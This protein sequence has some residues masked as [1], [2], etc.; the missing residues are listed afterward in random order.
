MKEDEKTVRLEVQDEGDGISPE[1]MP[2]I[3]DRYHKFSRNFSRSMTNTG[4]GLAIVK[5]ICDY[6]GWTIEYQ[7]TWNQH[8]F[9][10]SFG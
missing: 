10:V 7:Y 3:W 2:Y 1:D 4:L 6:H 9:V 8:C 5:A